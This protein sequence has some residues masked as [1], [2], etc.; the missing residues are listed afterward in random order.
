MADSQAQRIRVVFAA[1]G[2]AG[3]VEPALATADMI[4]RIEPRAHIS[5]LAT[6]TGIENQLVPPRGY[7]LLMVPKAAIPRGISKD[8]ILLP[9]KLLR[10]VAQT[11]KAIAG[12]DV[13]IG[14]GGYLAGAA[15][16]AAKISGIPIVVHEANAKAGLANQLGALFATEVA[17]CESINGISKGRVIGLPMRESIVNWATDVRSDAKKFRTEARLA[18]GISPSMQTLVVMG[19]SQGSLRINSAIAD[20]LDLILGKEIQ[21]IHAVG[22]RNELPGKKV[23]YF[24]S[25]YLTKMEL[26]YAAADLLIARS[27]AATCQEVLAFGLPTIFIPLPHGNG[28]QGLNARPIAQVGAAIVIPDDQTTGEKLAAEVIDLIKDEAKL[29]EMHKASGQLAHLD[30]AKRLAELVITVARAKSKK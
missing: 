27:G 11:K 18:L 8:L 24:P 4:Q 30:S 26:V 21:V 6:A 20:A 17:L 12:A 7:D 13:V 3:H 2:T 15:Y 23:G 9:I 1:G 16:I 28:E 14:F 5:F 29:S 25:Q 22:G 19:G 10:A